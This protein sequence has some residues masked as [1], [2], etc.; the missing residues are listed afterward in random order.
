MPI[1]PPPGPRANRSRQILHGA[2]HLRVTSPE[3]TDFTVDVG[4][5]PVVVSAGLVPPGTKGN[6]A[7]RS[8]GLPGG[9]VRFAPIETSANGKLRAAEDQCDNR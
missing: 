1:S 8:A 6:E 9:T 4:K 3:G 5:R 2:K 7:Q